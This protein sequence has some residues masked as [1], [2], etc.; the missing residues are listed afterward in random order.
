MIFVIWPVL[1]WWAAL[2]H[3]VR[4][5]GNSTMEVLQKGVTA[6]KPLCS[7]DHGALEND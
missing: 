3:L 2:I 1:M 6:L 4:K 5:H 7:P